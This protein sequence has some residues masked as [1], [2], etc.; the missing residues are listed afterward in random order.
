VIEAKKIDYVI[1]PNQI[2]QDASIDVRA[3]EIIALCG[4]NGAGKSCLLDAVLFALGATPVPK[5]TRVKSIEHLVNNGSGGA[6]GP[7]ARAGTGS[8]AGVRTLASVSARPCVQQHNHWIATKAPRLH[9]YMY[10]LMRFSFCCS[11][12]CSCPT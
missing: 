5:Y 6:H 2:L 1:G 3:G 10:C 8:G 11:S 7:G 4:P 9:S 12:L